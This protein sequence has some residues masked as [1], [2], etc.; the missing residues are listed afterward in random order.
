MLGHAT[1]GCAALKDQIE[2]LIR[3]GYLSQYVYRPD[4]RRSPQD[5][6][7]RQRSRNPQTPHQ[8]ID[9]RN[10]EPPPRNSIFRVIDTISGGF[11]GGGES[12]SARKQ[13]LRA[14][15]SINNTEKKPRRIPHHPMISFTEED[16]KGIN[17]NL[18]DPMVI[19]VVTANFWVK[20]VLIDQG[21]SADLMYLSVLKKMRI[22]EGKLKPFDENLISFSGEQVGVR[23][24][25]DFPTSFRTAPLVK[26]IYIRYLVIDCQ[27]PYNVLLGR[28]SLNKIGAV[29]STPYLTMK[30]P[31]IDTKVGT[32][33]VDQKEARQC[34]HDSL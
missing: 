13:H 10:V 9:R 12:S 28:P 21:S 6:S 4:W 32:I 30:F 1:E 24:Y 34:Y 11:T 5:N 29:V 26:T 7:G 14:V 17:Q 27:T 16:F 33:H 22:P 31:V 18:N 2:Q 23:G 20:K 8:A 15:M 19:S 25:I 3:K